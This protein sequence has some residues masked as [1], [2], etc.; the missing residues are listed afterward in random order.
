MRNAKLKIRE[1]QQIN[2][3]LVKKDIKGLPRGVQP[4]GFSG[5]YWK[6]SSLGPHIKYTNTNE[7]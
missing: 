6:K 5:P 4:F 7:N 1:Q 2:Y 3:D